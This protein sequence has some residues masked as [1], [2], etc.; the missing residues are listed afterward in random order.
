[1][2][3]MIDDLLEGT[4]VPR[5]MVEAAEI[6]SFDVSD[7]WADLPEKDWQ[8]LVAPLLLS[9]PMRPPYRLS[10]WEWRSNTPLIDAEMLRTPEIGRVLRHRNGTLLYD[11]DPSLAKVAMGPVMLPGQERIIDE[12]VKEGAE[13]FAVGISYVQMERVIAPLCVWA[14][15][16]DAQGKAIPRGDGFLLI[17]GSMSREED[18]DNMMINIAWQVSYFN[19][20]LHVRNVIALDHGYPE[21]LQLA[22]TRRGSEPFH[23]YKTLHIVT[24]AEARAHGRGEKIEL[25]E[26]TM[27]AHLV[28]GHYISFSS[29]RPAFGRPWGVGTFWIPAHTRGSR[30]IGE[31]E[32]DY[33]VTAR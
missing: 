8:E 14:M 29:E 19:A 23:A 20:M 28:R 16:L 2:A 7:L 31:V 21:K 11:A 5:P 9:T 18:I 33:K 26:R 25:A 24:P 10:W 30:E 32:K 27:P 4:S 12:A 17:G 15:S 13:R 1:M 3:K 22:R 6:V